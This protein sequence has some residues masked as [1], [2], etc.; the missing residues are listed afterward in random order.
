M[1]KSLIIVQLIVDIS[2][3]ES[4]KDKKMYRKEDHLTKIIFQESH[5][6]K[7]CKIEGILVTFPFK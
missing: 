7:T 1:D 5:I 2:K 3:C 4:F 6:C